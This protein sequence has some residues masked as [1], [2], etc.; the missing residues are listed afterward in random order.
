MKRRL[1]SY[2]ERGKKEARD[3]KRG[4]RHGCIFSPDL[5]NHHIDIILR[6]LEILPGFI[7]GSHNLDN[8]R[9]A[10]NTMLITNTKRKLQEFLNKV[11]MES[12]KKR[13]TICCKKTMSGHL[14]EEE[15]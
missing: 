9:Y 15:L 4:M 11:V 5:I 1:E 12:E 7:I 3:I 6:E 13:L 10:D 8:I 2:H 14:Q